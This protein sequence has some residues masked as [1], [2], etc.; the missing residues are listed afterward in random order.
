M[1]NRRKTEVQ[2]LQLTLYERV[3]VSLTVKVTE[4]VFVTE[5]TMFCKN[6]VTKQ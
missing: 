5:K 6:K 4:G 3:R 2:I 1:R